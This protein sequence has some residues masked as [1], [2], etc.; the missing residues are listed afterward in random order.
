MKVCEKSATSIL[1][2][3]SDPEAT[4]LLRPANLGGML[5]KA[6]ELHAGLDHSITLGKSAAGPGWVCFAQFS[7]IEFLSSAGAGH[8]VDEEFLALLFV[9][10]PA[11]SPAG[12]AA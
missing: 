6:K 2:T 3:L 11:P 7:A 12:V 4:V 5:A 8:H 1:L 9:H 10:R